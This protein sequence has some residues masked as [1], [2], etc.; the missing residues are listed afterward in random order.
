[1]KITK[2]KLQIYYQRVHENI[3]RKE[4]AIKFNLSESRI[5][6]IC[7]EVKNYIFWNYYH[8]E[9]VPDNWELIKKNK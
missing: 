6:Q 1:M 7:N 9:M 8:N 5:T 2:I 3:S 4:T